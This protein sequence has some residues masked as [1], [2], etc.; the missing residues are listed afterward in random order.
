MH[1]CGVDVSYIRDIDDNY[2]M[3]QP[4]W[5]EKRLF[6]QASEIASTS[7]WTADQWDDFAQQASW[8]PPEW[9]VDPRKLRGSFAPIFSDTGDVSAR[10]YTPAPAH[11]YRGILHYFQ[12]FE[13]IFVS[14]VHAIILAM[15]SGRPFVICPAGGELMVATG[16]ISG[17][18]EVERTLKQQGIL[19]REAFRESRGVI[20]N[21]RYLDHASLTG[22]QTNLL[23]LFP[24]SK[25]V[26]VSL[27]FA[28]SP[29]SNASSKR[30]LLNATLAELGEA[31]IRH[32]FSVFIPSRIDF[33]WKG[34]DIIMQAIDQVPEAADFAFIFS[35]WGADLERLTSWAAGRRNVR[36]LGKAMSWPVL[37]DLYRGSDL[38]I[39]QLRLGHIGTAARE[40][41]AAGTPV[42]AYIESSRR[43]RAGEGCP[44]DRPELPVLNACDPA[45]VA[46][47]LRGIASGAVDLELHA[48]EG[49]DWIVRY[50]S[51]DLMRAALE[52]AAFVD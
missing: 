46:A 4:I 2:A 23:R 5:A 18:G 17:E 24:Q 35:G 42:M 44:G 29:I 51:S 19:L 31:P 30:K 10:N 52:R 38:V 21:T 49:R 48:Q 7:G 20:T 40:A 1:A 47:W 14:N 33:Q 22:N 13:I 6:M 37:T 32:A 43:E 16:Q 39:D 9:I 25:L 11:F 3:S 41:A 12:T 27:P 28:V 8:M 34:Q 45:T 50:A 36:M 26:R 15:L